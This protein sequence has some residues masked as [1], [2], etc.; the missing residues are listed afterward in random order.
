MRLDKL[1]DQSVQ[2]LNEGIRYYKFENPIS[3]LK[4]FIAVLL[5]KDDQ[6]M[7][8]Y[9][10]EDIK[11]V[12]IITK[13]RYMSLGSPLAYE[14][15]VTDFHFEFNDGTSFYFLWPMILEDDARFITRILEEKVSHIKDE[16]QALYAMKN[17]INLNDY[18]L[19][20]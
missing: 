10:Y 17:G 4:Y 18:Y 13:L 15:Y 14:V 7:H 9:R 2:F 12:E 16:K 20:K 19:N 5:G 6:L 11:E 1:L 3:N 8:N